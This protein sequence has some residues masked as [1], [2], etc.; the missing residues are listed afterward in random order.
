MVFSISLYS[1]K[2]ET[3]V[4]LSVGANL[5]ISITEDY[6]II[7]QNRSHYVTADEESQW[8]GLDK[9]REAHRSIWNVLTAETILFGEWVAYKHSIHYTKLPGY[10]IAFDIYDKKKG[11]FL[12]RGERD[13]VLEGS[14][15]PVVKLIGEGVFSKEQYLNFLETDSAYTEGKV[16][17]VYARMDNGDHLEKRGKVVRP[18]FIQNIDVHWSKM[19]PVKNIVVATYN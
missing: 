4:F 16:E 13:K 1:L 10:F 11:K 8:K 12:S 9:W 5:G 7:Y 17:G 15:I 18:D 19:T 6:K 14:E 2:I 3:Q